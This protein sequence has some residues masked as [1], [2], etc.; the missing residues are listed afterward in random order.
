LDSSQDALYF[1]E[2]D[3]EEFGKV[4]EDDGDNSD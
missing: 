4:E 3:D 2:S 1:L